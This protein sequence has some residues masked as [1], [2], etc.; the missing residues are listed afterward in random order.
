LRIVKNNNAKTLTMNIQSL[1]FFLKETLVLGLF[2]SLSVYAW[3]R[4]IFFEVPFSLSEDGLIIFKT[5]LCGWIMMILLRLTWLLLLLTGQKLERI[6][7][8]S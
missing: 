5:I 8:R 2:L 1:K 7:S 3:L 6:F 4:I